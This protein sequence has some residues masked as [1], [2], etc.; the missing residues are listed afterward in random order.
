MNNLS[1]KRRC[2]TATFIPSTFPSL[3]P[4][5]ALKLRTN[6]NTSVRH[7]TPPCCVLSNAIPQTTRLKNMVEWKQ[8]EKL[9]FDP[10]GGTSNTD[11][12]VEVVYAYPNEYAV[13]ICSLGYQIVWATL[14]AMS[15]V[16]V[17]RLFTDAM[18][19]L[20][21]NVDLLGFSMSWELDYKG[22]FAQL[23]FVNIA[24]RAEQRSESDPIVFGGGP[25]LT[26][27]PEPFADFFDVI[28]LGDGEDTIP[29]FIEEIRMCRG[30]SRAEKLQR[31]AKIPGVYV[32]SLFQVQY[33]SSTGPLQ[34]ISALHRMDQEETTVQKATFR[35]SRLATST[36]VT[37]RCAWENIFMVEAVR[38]CPEM[39]AF[40]LASYV[41]LPFRAAPIHDQLIPSIDK[42]LEVTNR[43]G[44]LGAS[45]TQHPRFSELLEILREPKY[46][47]MRLSLSSVRT[48]TV[49]KELASTLVKRGSKSITVAVE[50]GSQRLRE[51]S[52]I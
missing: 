27:N 20:P 7:K 41:T 15:N 16:N 42:A 12:L 11:E 23:E 50:S 48:N 34:S 35:G 25:V 5:P 38:S 40:C 47:N 19:S 33:E 32:P 43:I 44:I 3:T 13:G 52:Y 24:R 51:V 26:A 22:I 29:A 4:F 36:V 17:T 9:F 46:E 30:I 45:V 28:L 10:Y 49:T 21:Y 8:D 1:L 39:C 14:C 37:P 18:E 6:T 2:R 31:L